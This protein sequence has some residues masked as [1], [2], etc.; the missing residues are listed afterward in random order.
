[1]QI[2]PFYNYCDL[3]IL[4]HPSLLLLIVN[5]PKCHNGFQQTDCF[6][7]LTKLRFLHLVR[8]TVAHLNLSIDN[9]KIER[10]DFLNIF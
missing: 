10:V 8:K 9:K 7:I 6:S 4:A 2:T 5:K 1:M 3:N